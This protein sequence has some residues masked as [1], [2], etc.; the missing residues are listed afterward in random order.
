M[1]AAGQ[2]AGSIH[3][4]G[5]RVFRRWA[6]C[7]LLFSLPAIALPAP[8][9]EDP[10]ALA[11]AELAHDKLDQA[12]PLFR[13]VMEESTPGSELWLR[14]AYG[15]GICLHQSTPATPERIARA[16]ETY[17]A[18]IAA[19][20]DTLYG[21]RARFQIGN[22][23]EWRDFAGDE[24]DYEEARAFYLEVAE[25]AP[26][27]PVG[28]EA[29][30]RYACT[31]VIPAYDPPPGIDPYDWE[32]RRALADPGVAFLLEHLERRPRDAFYRAGWEFLSLAYAHLY[33]DFEKALE[34]A[35]KST[36]DYGM[37]HGEPP[38]E[39][40]KNL[41]RINPGYMYWRIAYLARQ[42]GHREIAYE[43]YTQIIR[44]VPTYKGAHAQRILEEMGFPPEAIPAIEQFERTSEAP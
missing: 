38:V 16:R 28:F 20:P 14:A 40:K 39:E 36:G 4:D 44:E 18:I 17:E 6:L 3:R 5:F 9:G 2:T 29:V 24:R 30:L 32:A 13:E 11:I 19:A 31:F 21:L 22:I 12:E 27:E 8:A 23:L 25:Q 41:D 35:L 34:A 7:W 37:L 43:Y 10:L 33:G 26:D 1:N 42:L 15:Y